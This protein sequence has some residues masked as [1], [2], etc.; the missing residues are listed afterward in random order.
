[1]SGIRV[2]CPRYHNQGPT[3]GRHERTPAHRHAPQSNQPASDPSTHRFVAVRRRAEDRTLVYHPDVLQEPNDATRYLSAAA[4]GDK[5]AADALLPLVYDQLRKVAQRR[6]E[7][8]RSGHT[9]SATGLVHEAYLKLVGPR[10]IP[11]AGRG[12]FYAAAAEAMRRILVD[13]ARAHGRS[14]GAKLRLFEVGDVA[15]LAGLGADE[16][17]AVDEAIRRLE[18]EDPQA[19]ALVRLR[20]YAG[21]DVE[22]AAK[23]LQV[24]PRT[25][26]RL[27]TYARAA[28]YLDLSDPTERIADEPQRR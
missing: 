15:A 1:L 24:S 18:E 3:L 25:A 21:L 7:G 8:E 16:I 22:D 14:G 19:A 26:A 28:L 9:L 20:F 27:W 11:W 2:N 17:L 4:E 23:A 13:H 10:E 12:H 5:A 6:L